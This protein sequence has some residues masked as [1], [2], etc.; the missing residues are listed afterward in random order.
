MTTALLN[1]FTRTTEMAGRAAQHPDEFAAYQ[2]GLNL[3]LRSEVD[4]E[5]YAHWDVTPTPL[6][7][8][9]NEWEK[10]RDCSRKM[11]RIIEKTVQ[12]YINGNEELD[13]LFERYALFR[14]Y[15][16]KRYTSWQEYG[17]YDF[18]VG[19]D[20]EP[21]YIETN[22]AMASGYL[23]MAFVN[24][25]FAESAPDFLRPEGERC[26]L[27]YDSPDA[28]GH[29]LV[30][31][32]TVAGSAYGTVAIIV[33]ENRKFHEANL[34]KATLENVGRKVVIGDVRQ[35]ERRGREIFLNGEL[36]STTFNKFRLFGAEHHWS[37]KAFTENR[38]FLEAVADNQVLSVNNFA[39]MTVSEDKSIFAAMRLPCVQ[40]AL[41]HD[42]REFVQ[43]H[44]MPTYPLEPGK[45]YH[46]NREVDLIPFL[47]Q[48]RGD[49]ILKPRS[50]YRGSGTHSGRDCTDDEWAKLIDGLQDQQ[51]LAQQRVDAATYD[52]TYTMDGQVSTRSMRM[53]GGIYFADADFQGL[54]AR[55]ATWEI[56]NAI[57]HAH[58]LPVY[59]TR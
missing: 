23:P 49:F 46:E 19:T 14:P 17:R 6:A 35:L 29:E 50:D 15:M 26:L 20:G 25:F 11:F 21:V 24:R 7:L 32:E 39:A 53:A 43:K 2:A 52:V 34:I 51:Y 13:S 28:L 37:D 3:R 5:F 40:N 38:I 47:K 45:V 36:V 4:P 41:S 10:L 56:I 8:N 12:M 1:T 54:V 59:V 57:N 16:T 58:V 18:I 22:T 42:E 31:M 27:P 30:R 33:D 9:W 44:T 55:A 48:N